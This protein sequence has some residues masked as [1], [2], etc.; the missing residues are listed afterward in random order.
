[1][2]TDVVGSDWNNGKM[3]VS[4]QTT[5]C[6]AG[7]ASILAGDLGILTDED[8]TIMKN[9]RRVFPIHDIIKANGDVMSVRSR[10]KE[11]LGLTE[12]QA[13]WLFDGYRQLPEVVNALIELSE[14]KDMTYR[15]I[16][17]M[18]DDEI[19]RLENHRV[20]PTVARKHVA[21]KAAAKRVATNVAVR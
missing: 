13:N 2:A 10:G 1:V 19:K 8:S 7:T 18:D 15:P 4:C 11:L 20:R 3:E 5:G 12:D 16:D 17:Q 9:G 14:G 6:V 21:K